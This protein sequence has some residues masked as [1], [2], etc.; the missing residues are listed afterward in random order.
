MCGC[1]QSGALGSSRCRPSFRADLI[2]TASSFPD[3]LDGPFRLAGRHVGRHQRLNVSGYPPPPTPFL[4]YCG[5][6]PGLFFLLPA[7]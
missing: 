5:T 1:S 4:I 6:R 7:L 2:F 3:P